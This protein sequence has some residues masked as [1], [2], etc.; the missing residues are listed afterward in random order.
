MY[1]WIYAIQHLIDWIDEHALENPSLNEIAKQVGYSP[2]YC[3]EQFHRIAGMTIKSYMAKRRLC[4]AAL[5]I[6]D[7]DKPISDISLEF[8]FSSQSALTRA[9]M[10]VYG[11]TPAAYRRNPV[12][13]PISIH[14]IVVT[15]AHYIEEGDLTMSNLVMPS[16]HVEYIPAHKY[17]GVYEASTTKKGKIWPGHD[18]DLLTGIVTSFPS[19][20]I[21]PV[22]TGHT[23][24]WANENGNKE[25]FYGLGVE[26][27]YSGEILEGFELRGEF[28]GSY[29]LVF[30]HPPFDY[31]AENDEVM[32]RVENLAWS[33]DPQTAGYEWN[34][35]V[36]QDYQRHY[37]ERLGYQILRPVRKKD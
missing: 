6:R 12:P 18:C 21:H 29:Y 16:Y 14:K 5:A 22:V 17:L 25:Y 37:P 34:E 15:P 32:K 26:S 27:D 24:G 7:T 8:G 11:C 20:I 19:N 3:S 36:C 4:K 10:D 30:S 13:I 28:P 31:L 35:E 2:Y 9:F 33:F 1:E 23:A